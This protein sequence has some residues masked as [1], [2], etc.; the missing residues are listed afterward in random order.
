MILVGI[1]SVFAGCTKSAFDASQQLLQT[2]TLSVRIAPEIHVT[3]ATKAVSNGPDINEFK[4]EIYKCE[5]QNLV[6]LYRDTYENTVDK[7]IALNAADYMIHARHGDSLGVGFQAIYYAAQANLTVHPQT[8][9][10]VNLEAK[11]ANVKVAVNYGDNL[12]YDWPE[13]YAKVKCTT[14]GGR[15]RTLEFSQTET[16]NGYM[17]SGQFV[18][19]LYIKVGEDWMYYH[20]PEM[21]IKPNDFV[22]FN[23]DTE[24]AESKATLTVSVDNGVEVIEKQ[25]E[26]SS[27]WLPKDAPVINT[28]DNNG[29]DF[30]NKTY[31]LIEAANSNLS[32]LKANIVAP[33]LINHCYLEVTSEYLRAR[34]VPEVVDLAQNVDPEVE[35]ALKSIGLRW[36]NAMNG[37]RLGYV[38]FTGIVNWIEQQTCDPANLLTAEFSLRVEDQRQAMGQA[39]MLPVIF[40][41]G[42]PEFDFY[43]IP[44]YNC[45]AKRI[46]N[47]STLLISGNPDA[48]TLEYK[49]ST[50]GEDA[51]VALTP[52]TGSETNAKIYN[53]RGLEPSTTYNFR[54]RYNNNPLT[55]IVRTATTEAAGQ[56]GN[57][58]FENWTQQTY[59]FNQ[60]ASGENPMKWYQPWTGDDQWWDTNA[61]ASMK[62]DLTIGYTWFKSFPLVHYSTD[63][64]SGSRSAQITVANVGNTNSTWWTR[65]TWYVGQLFLGRGND[66]DDWKVSSEGHVFTSRPNAMSFWYKYTPDGS[67]KGS[68]RVVIMSGSTELVSS[69]S[70]ISSA[71]DW[72]QMRV[73]LGDYKNTSLK[74]THIYVYFLASTSSSHSPVGGNGG[75]YIEIAGETR[76]SDP[77]RIKLA[78]LLKVDDVA[79]IYD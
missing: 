53:L 4:V 37:Q 71:S 62:Y 19:E 64:H 43:E 15:K 18:V 56:V 44:S 35:A 41:Q 73:S 11:M 29:N 49:K 12:K 79:L 38:D 55:E 31:S 72:T 17:P 9:E 6:R 33:G 48:F 26:V 27:T 51:W 76:K 2:G 21:S 52:G 63:A 30:T 45:W 1:V 23:V 68:V 13:Y 25:Y 50:Q 20:S 75:S 14:K 65:G 66:S 28:L 77:Y 54:A 67:D 34:G 5:S 59:E 10:V 42:K 7:K 40:K 61:K 24:K 57:N 32:C 22:T 8:D 3:N 69:T 47:V 78:S 60:S 36:L 74:A 46:D 39:E 70:T 58:G 16:R